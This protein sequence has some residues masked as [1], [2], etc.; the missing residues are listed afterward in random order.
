MASRKRMA[1]ATGGERGL[2]E[3]GWEYVLSKLLNNN[4]NDSVYDRKCCLETLS[5]VSKQFLSITNHSVHSFALIYNPSPIHR[6]FQRF[7]NL[8]SL[9]LSHFRGD[10]N[11]LLSRFPISVSHLT[12]LNLSNHP[13]FPALGLK[14]I[15]NN[16][17]TS[18]TCSNIASLK[19]TDIT[20]IAD[21][22]LF[23]QHL[24][25]SFPRG[26]SDDQADHYN[27]AFNLLTHKL[28]K[29]RKVNLSGHFYIND[30]SFLQLC[31]NCVF[32][33]EVVIFHC[34]LITHAGIASAIRHR[35]TLNSFS[36]TNFKE[37]KEIKNLNSYFIDSFATLRRLTCLDLS[38]S[39]ITDSLLYSLARQPPPL[40]KLVLQGCSH[41]TY[42]GISHLLSKCPSLQHLGLQHAK[43]FNDQLFIDLCAFLGDLV[44]INVSG[45]DELTDSAFFALLKNCP[46]LTEIRMEATNIGIGPIPS[47]MDSVVY[48]QVKSL[49]LAFN[50]RLQDKDI[51]TFSLMFPNMQLLD[52]TYCHYISQEG[53]D[54]L[55]NRCR[56][57][58]HLYFAFIPLDKPFSINFEASS[59]EVLN[60]SHSRIDDEVL[61]DISKI[62][63]R[64]LQ[65]NL[66]RCY[67]VTEKGVRL[68]VE[69]CTH[70]REIN[71]QHCPKVSTDIVSW[72]IFSRPSLRKIT[73][74]PHFRPHECDRK[75][76][77]GRCLV[78]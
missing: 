22:F 9:G 51:N 36:V 29:L 25:I 47:S 3:D 6:L 11:A 20:F 65:L 40:T 44:S 53:V 60:L 71:L 69:N 4:E 75:L 21:S 77:F 28:S 58:R 42:T 76:L 64:L 46:L 74:P 17:L 62:C 33:Q 66:K 7:P 12:S 61:Y 49:Y 15:L 23:L 27:N 26:L 13:T 70:L 48:H 1:T 56:K 37:A 38:F 31:V 24:D 34:P 55:L 5:L 43:F 78:S 2:P 63:P 19:F 32:L 73:A 18:L 16:T 50:S 68:V 72:M 30:S 39:C 8:T 52:L 35:P 14:T 57:I 41:Y 10:L 45:C 54:I 67:K 59:L